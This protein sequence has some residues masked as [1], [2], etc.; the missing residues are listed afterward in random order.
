MSEPNSINAGD[1][2]VLPAVRLYG[3]KRWQG[4]WRMT[5]RIRGS[6]ASELVERYLKMNFV[7]GEVLSPIFLVNRELEFLAEKQPGDSK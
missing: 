4:G 6:R 1:D 3:V 7:L 5:Q 2:F